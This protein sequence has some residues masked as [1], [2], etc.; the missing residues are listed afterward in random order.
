MDAAKYPSVWY[1]V[2]KYM[3]GSQIAR[4]QETVYEDAFS[5]PSIPHRV[6]YLHPSFHVETMIK[7]K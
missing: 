4:I 5:L 1:Y 2:D 3:D 6:K 7:K